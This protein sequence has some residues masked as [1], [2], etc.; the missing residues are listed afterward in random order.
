M[1]GVTGSLT[2][3]LRA[4]LRNAYCYH[5][6]GARIATSY[7]APCP[8][9]SCLGGQPHQVPGEEMYA[10]V[11]SRIRNPGTSDPATRRPGKGISV[12][13]CSRAASRIGTS[14]S[15]GSE[16]M[17]RTE[18]WLDYDFWTSIPSYTQAR[19]SNLNPW[20]TLIARLL[21]HRVLQGL[22]KTTGCWLICLDKDTCRLC[23]HEIKF[24]NLLT[25]GGPSQRQQR[26]LQH[27]THK[28]KLA[29]ALPP[30]YIERT[31]PVSEPSVGVAFS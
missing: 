10:L 3:D 21:M 15:S 5:R 29:P 30:A 14:R 8:P 26:T 20:R 2:G 4:L 31:V 23:T 7:T 24:G 22:R 6:A 18:A 17:D 13:L 19:E 12:A 11:V 27:I 16:K 25:C 28:S 9:G 1:A